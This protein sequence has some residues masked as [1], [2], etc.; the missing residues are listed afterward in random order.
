[1]QKQPKTFLIGLGGAAGSVAAVKRFLLA[2]GNADGFAAIVQLRAPANPSES[3][4]EIFQS[5]TPIKVIDAK[6]GQEIKAG[7]IFVARAG[8]SAQVSAGYIKVEPCKPEQSRP[9]DKLFRSLAKAG[10]AHAA[11]IL[12]SGENPD[13]VT[14]IDDLARA[15]GF[16]LVQDPNTADHRTMVETAIALGMVDLVGSPERLAEALLAHIGRL[17]EMPET[18]RSVEVHAHDVSE[19]CQA[20]AAATGHDFRHY[21]TSTL[22]RRISRR[23]N[24]TGS[25]SPE[26]YLLRLKDNPE[27]ARQLMR[28]LLIGVTSF[29]RDPSAF[30]ALADAALKPIIEDAPSAVRVWVPGCGTGQEV[31]SLAMLV[32]ELL[33]D[34][35]HKAD[36]QLFATDLDER[37]L[38][39]ARRGIYPRSIG[40]EVNASRL[41]RFFEPHGHRFQISRELRKLVVFSPHNLVSDPPFSRLNLI[42]CRNLLIY[43]GP[44]LQD[45]LMSVFHYSLR[46]GGFLFL[47]SS[48]SVAGHSELFRIVDAKHR[49]AQRKSAGAYRMKTPRQ[50]GTTTGVGHVRAQE[51]AEADIGAL[52]QRMVLDEFSPPYAI[53]NQDAQIVYLSQRIGAFLQ[54]PEGEYSNNIFRMARSG[55]RVGLR[56]AW[57]EAHELRRKAVYEGLSVEVEGEPHFIRLTVQPMPEVG[58][59]SG[60]AMIVFQ[61]MGPVASGSNSSYPPSPEEAERLVAKLE[62]ELLRTRDELERA[63]QDLEAANEELKSSNEELLSMNEEL[64]SSN[65]ELES[66]KDEVEAANL[67]LAG[68]N[69]DLQNLLHSTELATIF[70]DASGHLRR[71]TPAATGLFNLVPG[72]IGRP[73]HHVTHVLESVT[74]PSLE[75]IIGAGA[76][77][78]CEVRRQDGR[79]FLQRVTP[80]RTADGEPSGTV[81]TFLDITQQKETQNRLKLAEQE[82]EARLAELESVYTTAPVGLTLLDRDFRYLR[83]NDALAE[84]NGFPA[85]DHIG[86]SLHDMVPDL[87]DD[88][89]PLLER[90]LE[91]GQT[92]GPNEITGET[93][94]ESGHQR[95]WL[96]SWA[97]VVGPLGA[98]VGVQGSMKDIT[99]RKRAQIALTASEARLRRLIDNLFAFVSILTPDGTLIESNRAPLE[100][101][102]LTRDDVIGKPFWDC[103]WW[104]FSEDSRQRLRQ[105]FESVLDGATERYDVE[106]RIDPD[107]FIMVDFQMAPVKDECGKVIEVVS[108]CIDISDRMKVERQRELLIQELNHRVKNTLATIQAIAHVSIKHSPS[109][110]NFAEGFSGRLLAIARAHDALVSGTATDTDLVDV[111]QRQVGPYAEGPKGSLAMQGP[112]VTLSASEAHNLGLILHELATN[113]TKHGSL[114]QAGGKLRISWTF[115]ECGKRAVIVWRESGG[116]RVEAPSRDG[117]GSRLVWQMTE[118]LGGRFN[119]TYDPDGFAAELEFPV[120][121]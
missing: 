112:T 31:Y 3:A 47:G 53:V 14:G 4:A 65:E 18:S 51:P 74:I 23:I 115:D 64:Q 116:P 5:S 98:I 95:T 121:G 71:Y 33:D 77:L 86:K 12:F 9:I 13:G 79:T 80:Y 37:A 101:A 66:S 42:S 16:I 113:A 103:F 46:D 29:F 19:I 83:I 88:L 72:D 97:P 49:I 62:A 41:E 84:M 21:K 20:L 67:A 32:T 85:K 102:D 107:R 69:A 119:P 34:A 35:G 117:F 82:A 59:A 61:I 56:A 8:E 28:D 89:M 58:H 108:S 76:R 100:V 81:V 57:G 70:V 50:T 44:Y 120:A 94:K 10:G 54:P 92:I 36:V 25:M 45:K 55:L 27:E 15:G 90:V 78:E 43:L 17:R 118:A 26:A 96:E 68:A 2:L 1:M 48:E 73:M 106:M 75:A 6:H 11:A 63:V 60:L 30:E 99:D 52:S 91:T 104:S 38:N 39:V 114:S 24:I 109:L 40:G 87:I 110:K 7:T 93:A 111:V 105:S 22:V